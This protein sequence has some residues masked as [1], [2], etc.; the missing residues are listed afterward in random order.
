MKH[1]FAHVHLCL[2]TPVL[3]VGQVVEDALDRRLIS[4]PIEPSGTLIHT[5]D[6]SSLSVGA[7][8]VRLSGGLSGQTRA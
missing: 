4:E 2:T 1:A 5:V 7:Y 8:F 6:V 3:L